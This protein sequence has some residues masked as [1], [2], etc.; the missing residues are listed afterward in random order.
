MCYKPVRNVILGKYIKWLSLL[1][2]KEIRQ[3]MKARPVLYLFV[4][5]V[6]CCVSLLGAAAVCAQNAVLA[7]IGTLTITEKDLNDLANAIPERYRDLYMS[8][9]ARQKTLDYIVNIYV[10]AAEAE[11]QNIDKAPEVQKL[12]DFTKKDLLARIYLD[13]MS[14]N[15]KPPTEEE[16]K[17]YYNQ[18]KDQ[19]VTPE[20]V[21]LHHI[22]VNTEKEAKAVMDRL[23]KG[24]KFADIASQVSIC[25]SKS[26]GGDL[27]W[28]PKGSLVPEIEET[29]FTA[30]Q[31]VP[32]G[33]VK[34]K[35]GYHVLLVE[36]RKPAEEGS[37]D[38]AREY[39][40]EQ[41]KFQAQQDNYE[42]I[43]QDLR[44]KMNVQVFEQATPAPAPTPS[45]GP[46]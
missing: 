40:L 37:F 25:P 24:E 14:R 4:T 42:R 7:K 33:P 23:K 27:G 5:M 11:K 3:K 34:S 9:E 1:V 44:K 17:A 6:V 31:G 36:D 16:A 41:L 19:F 10:L 26:K 29:A 38:Q 8:P 30:K 12:M 21:H 46:K 45:G 18:Y 28:L 20:S 43:A 13:R 32:T 35:F 22:L 2:I 15:L 39:I